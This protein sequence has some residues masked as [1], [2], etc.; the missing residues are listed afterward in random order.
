VD[1]VKVSVP[2]ASASQSRLPARVDV[3]DLLEGAREA[4]LVH[5]GQEYRLRITSNEKLILTK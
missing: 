1:G 2:Q 3:R 4:V 5:D